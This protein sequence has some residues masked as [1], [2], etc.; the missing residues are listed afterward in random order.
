MEATFKPSMKDRRESRKLDDTNPFHNGVTPSK[1]DQ[2]RRESSNKQLDWTP[3]GNSKGAGSS[4]KRVM[5]P[6]LSL[7]PVLKDSAQA[8]KMKRESIKRTQASGAKN[9]NIT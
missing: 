4:A 1:K 3:T 9:M 8:K 7:T 5:S 2:K 6:R